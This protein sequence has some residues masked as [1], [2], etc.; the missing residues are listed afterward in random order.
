MEQVDALL[1]CS[2]LAVQLPQKHLGTVL[3]PNGGQFYGY[4]LAVPDPGGSQS[5]RLISSEQTTMAD[6]AVSNQF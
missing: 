1:H 4:R 2:T 5:G 6:G 3:R